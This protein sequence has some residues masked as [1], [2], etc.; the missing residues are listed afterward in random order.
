MANPWKIFTAA[1]VFAATAL[2]I[3][4]SMPGGGGNPPAVSYPSVTG[5]DV[6]V[7]GGAYNRAASALALSSI[8]P[9][10]ITVS[11]SNANINY[12]S[13]DDK[14]STIGTITGWGTLTETIHE[15]ATLTG[16]FDATTGYTIG[17]TITA[18]MTMV[19]TLGGVI[20][21]ITE[22][23]VADLDF[24]GTGPVKKIVIGISVVIPY[25]SGVPGTPTATG[26][27]TCNGMAFTAGDLGSGS[28]GGTR[29]ATPTFA[30]VEG[31]YEVAQSVTIST[32]TVGAAIRYTT[33]GVT[34]P[35][36]TV[37][38]LYTGP[39][40][41]TANQTIMAIAYKTD[42][43]SSFVATS[44]YTIGTAMPTFTPAEGTYDTPQT[45]AL[46]TTTA[47]AAIR[48]T[49]DGVTTPTETVGTLYTSPISVTAK[50]TVKAVAYK[51]GLPDSA[52]STGAYAITYW[53][54]FGS[55][56]T[57][58][59]EFG[60]PC[61]VALDTDKRIYVIDGARIAQFNDM[62]G[63]GWTT[64]DGSAQFSSPMGIAVDSSKRIY[65]ADQNNYR[66][67]RMNDI[68]GAGWT[69][70][71]TFGSG[72][73]QFKNP[74]GLAFDSIGRIYVADYNNN[75]IVR[76]NDMDGSGWI[77][78]S[79]ASHPYG[80]AFD[81]LGRI[82]VGEDAGV[83]RFD[84]MS[85]TNRV[86]FGTYGSGTNQ[87]SRAS[88][89]AVDASG[90]IYIAD[91]GG[92]GRIVAIDDMTGKGW[93]TYGTYGTGLHQFGLNCYGMTVG[94][95]K[96]LYIADTYNRRIISFLMP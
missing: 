61:G 57:G 22:G 44:R 48:Y 50:Q 53:T 36:E 45:V 67:I 4:C 74:A 30:P 43:T 79:L 56:G 13:P 78:C 8:P 27:V 9:T 25:H 5:P 47:G 88:G 90:R 11:G 23:E 37:G 12:R 55:Q 60:W 62:I 69:T 32:T 26:T 24:S 59:N 6:G 41:V 2:L 38:T 73:D 51:S 87:L 39:I 1:L 21:Q 19:F 28:S 3:S 29:A 16:L 86:S 95:D 70:W 93:T 18:D 92:N 34:T 7:A 82:Y 42:Y 14:L 49:T 91:G 65:I 94:T 76:M 31:T 52:V 77:S 83:E 33:D 85:G 15:V 89:I 68:S 64:F 80:V 46:S 71:G 35:K 81:S 63:T 17:G 72:T 58:T 40:D 66:I 84:D 96:K 54:T 75:R 10:A 20:S